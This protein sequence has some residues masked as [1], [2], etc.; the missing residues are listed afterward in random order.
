MAAVV[1]NVHA[2]MAIWLVVCKINKEMRNI[3]AIACI[4][5]ASSGIG[6]EFAIQLSKMGYRLILVSRNTHKLKKLAAGLNTKCKIIPCDLANEDACRNLA[7]RLKKYKIDILINNAGFGDLGKFSDT[8]ISKDLDMIDVNVKATHIL[9]KELL[10]RFIKRDYGYIMNVSSSAGLMPGGPYMAAY[11]AT[12]AYVSSFSSAIYQEL[13]EASSN[14]HICILCPG[15]VKT[16]FNNVANV[17][18]SIKGISAEYCVRYALTQMF[19]NKFIII[20][21]FYMKAAV[22]AARI[23][24]RK[25]ML[26]VLSQ[27]QHR[28]NIH[29]KKRHK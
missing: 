6:R 20:P 10:P 25:L 22:L 7:T 18:F 9:T 16:N 5:G 2:S 15:P 17:Q 8:N 11:Y 24:P 3:M 26:A 12:K 21:T 4:T 19:K 1:P 29:I 13:K 23:T 14:V 27:Q 28:K